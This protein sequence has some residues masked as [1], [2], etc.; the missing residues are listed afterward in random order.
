M[1][2]GPDEWDSHFQ[3]LGGVHNCELLLSPD[4]W[5]VLGQKI[6]QLLD[7]DSLLGLRV[8]QIQNDAFEDLRV[9]IMFEPLGCYSSVLF[10]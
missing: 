9:V 7:A 6:P 8:H 3:A 1:D 2:F 4:V 10:F 5:R